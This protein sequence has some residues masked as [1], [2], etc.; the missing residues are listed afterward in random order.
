MIE[1]L[2]LQWGEVVRV[3]G[4]GSELDGLDVK[5]V[6]VAI[7]HIVDFYILQF[8]DNVIR[9]MPDGSMHYTAFTLPESNLVRSGAR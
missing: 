3:V 9:R 8:R 4:T 6:G 5:V 7:R 1:K 2:N